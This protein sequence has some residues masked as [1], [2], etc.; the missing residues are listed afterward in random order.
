MGFNEALIADLRSH[1][2]KATSGPF[3]GRPLIVLTT[4]GARTRAERANPLVYSKDGDRIV[5]VAS[6]G[7]ADTNPDWFHNLKANPSVTVEVDTETFQGRANIVAS[8]SE[9]R[10]LYDAHAA[11]HPTFKDYEKKTSRVIPVV[12]LERVA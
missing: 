11:M 8:E 9:R 7:G 2:G 5:I 6:K 3:V 10:R 4:T 1:E 12:L